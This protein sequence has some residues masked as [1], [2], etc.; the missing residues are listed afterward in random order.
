VEE[1][2]E[3]GGRE[4]ERSLILAVNTCASINHYWPVKKWKFHC[5]VNHA[6]E[7]WKFHCVVYNHVSLIV[8]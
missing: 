5:V 4:A 7:K 1:A 2:G 3:E 6:M 8:V